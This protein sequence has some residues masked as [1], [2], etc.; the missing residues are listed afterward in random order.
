MERAYPNGTGGYDTRLTET[1]TKN[2]LM[3]AAA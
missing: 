2:A 3:L 1:I